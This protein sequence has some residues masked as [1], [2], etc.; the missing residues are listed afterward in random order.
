MKK[1]Y[2]LL[3]AFA[4]VLTSCIKN[5]EIVVTSSV[6]EFDAASYNGKAL[7]KNYPVLNRVPG[8]GRQVFTATSIGGLPADPTITRASGTITFRVNLVGPHSSTP[9]E[10]KY[11]VVPGET[12]AGSIAGLATVADAE[13]AVQGTDYTTSGTLT[14]PANSSFGLLTINIVNPGVALAKEK[15]IVLELSSGTVN[16]NPNYFRIGV[17]I[18]KG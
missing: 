12:Y 1:I 18:N 17:V 5:D 15:L 3:I 6:L 7:S 13:A 2:I 10:V 9:T 8:Y 11:R 4:T 14:I 16:P